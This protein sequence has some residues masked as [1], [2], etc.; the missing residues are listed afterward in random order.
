MSTQSPNDYPTAPK[1]KS[2]RVVG[3]IYSTSKGIYLW[4]KTK[5][6]R[7][8]Y[9]YQDFPQAG[10]LQRH[11]RTQHLERKTKRPEKPFST[12]KGTICVQRKVDLWS[13]NNPD[14]PDMISYNSHE[15]RRFHCINQEC[16]HDEFDQQICTVTR[17]NQSARAGWCPYCSPKPTL[18]D[19]LDCA[20]CKKRSFAGF[21]GRTKT[22]RLKVACWSQKNETDPRMVLR[23]S[24]TSYI[25]DCDKCPH[26]FDMAPNA[27]T[28][29]KPRWCRYC[30]DSSRKRCDDLMCT[31]CFNASFASNND[32]LPHPKGGVYLKISCWDTAANNGKRP[33]DYGE[34]GGQ[35]VAFCCKTCH[36]SF[37]TTIANVKNGDWCPYCSHHRFCT[38]IHCTHCTNKTLQNYQGRTSSGKLKIECWMTDKNEGL[39]PRDIKSGISNRKFW[40]K[41]DECPHS[42]QLSPGNMTRHHQWCPYC[43]IPTKRLCGNIECSHCFQRS[44]ASFEGKTDSGKRMVDC[45]LGDTPAHQICKASNHKHRFECDC[46]NH[47]FDTRISCITRADRTWCGRCTCSKGER[48]I[49]KALESWAIPFAASQSFPE[50]K[51]IK[52]LPFDAYI[53]RTICTELSVDL[54]IEFDGIQHF[55]VFPNFFHRKPGSFEKGQHHDRLKDAFCVDNNKLLLR[56]SYEELSEVEKW[57][58]YGLQFAREGRS[59]VLVSNVGLYKAAGVLSIV[60]DGLS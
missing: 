19:S 18:C 56:I 45:L 31:D 58:E 25:F 12:F 28:R 29:N 5:K 11:V 46:C 3:E 13:E 27:V 47:R 35:K 23:S 39:T 24:N 6:F 17:P 33:R 14:T 1:F 57:L 22:G 8:V 53:D 4:T 32:L 37:E 51:S 26:S 41:C 10:N 34:C 40:Y 50:C 38:D 44:F 15:T 9:C 21:T 54:F 49:H 48:C 60:N 43:S 30:A 2:K 55:K 36:H 7:C 20:S 16:S 42:F 59:G 52:A